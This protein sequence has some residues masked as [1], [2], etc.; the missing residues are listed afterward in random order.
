MSVMW[1]MR[2][3]FH[4][5]ATRMPVDI[6]SIEPA[7]TACMIA[8]SAP[9]SL[10]SANA[11][12]VVERVLRGR[13]RDPRPGLDRAGRAD[14]DEVVRQLGAGRRDPTPAAARSPV[15]RCGSR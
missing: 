9:S 11:N 10:T 1:P 6:A 5:G 15:H 13:L 3:A 12:G 4:R 7:S 14:V 8:V 2:S